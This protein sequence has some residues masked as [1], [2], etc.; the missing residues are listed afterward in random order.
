M[1][2]VRVVILVVALVAALGAAL[3]V[4]NM[5]KSAQARSQTIA[6]VAVKTVEKP[7]ARVLVAKHDLAVGERLA[8]GDMAWQS[9]PL[10]GVTPT[11]I[12]ENASTA[13]QVVKPA[14]QEASKIAQAATDAVSG[15]QGPMAALIGAVVREPM[16]AGE[17]IVQKKLVRAGSAGVMAVTLEPGMRAMAVP[18]T[19]E[20]A[21]GGFILPGDHVDVVQSRQVEGA[22]VKTFITNTVIKNVRILAIDQNTS[23][24]K[25]SAVVGATATLEVTPP[26]AEALLNAKSQGELTLTLRS[27]ADSSGPAI[28]TAAKLAASALAP[29][30]SVK[31]YRN[32][33]ASEVMVAR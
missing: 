2:P 16:D 7:T 24:E 31:V 32:G 25:G 18:L 6:P 8:E 21:A 17:P 11:F 29:P 28:V 5:T 14:G 33:Q 9:W 15:P 3:I 22:V 27:Y 30:P 4:R 19:A 10:E 1:G 13:S 12:T 20:S 26:Q 23:A